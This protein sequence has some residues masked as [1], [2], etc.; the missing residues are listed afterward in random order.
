MTVFVDEL[1]RSIALFPTPCYYSDMASNSGS[2]FVHK[3]VDGPINIL[4]E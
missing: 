1:E 2:Y 4:K 3:P